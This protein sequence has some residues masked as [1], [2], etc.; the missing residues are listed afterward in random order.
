MKTARFLSLLAAV[1]L[2]LLPVSGQAERSRFLDAAL[3]ML[4]EGNPFLTHYNEETGA[5]IQA[6]FPLGCPYFWGGWKAGRIL[7]PA[8]PDQNSDYYH[9]DRQYLYGMDCAGLT[10]WIMQQAGYE[11]HDSIANLLD[12][13]QYSELVVSHAK[14]NTGKE[15]SRWLQPGDLVALRHASGGYHIAMF[16]GTLLDF[17]YTKKNLPEALVPYLHHPLVI[18]CTGSSD[19]HERY[20]LWLE[21]SGRTD[22]VPP[23]GGVIVSLLDVPAEAATGFTPDV[24]D[25]PELKK[26]CFD[27]EG[28]RLEILDLSAEKRQR[29]IRWR[30]KPDQDP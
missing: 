1:M 9:S 21:E 12:T 5:E 18:H 29:W 27:L 28:Y 2:L 11:R 20:R 7:Q 10:R 24:P 19:Y 22:I 13:S 16:I 4:E 14:K 15:R 23:F 25:V 17:G 8:R 30:Q 3:S 26:P 6:R